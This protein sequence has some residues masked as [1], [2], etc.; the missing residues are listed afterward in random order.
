VF[1]WLQ[2]A[3]VPILAALI[4]CLRIVDVSLGTIRT[5]SVVEGRLRLSVLLGFFE[6]LIWITAVSQ[7]IQRIDES[8]LLLLAYAAGFAS[9]NAVGILIEQRI[10]MGTC[11]VRFISMER[12]PLLADALRENGRPVTTFVGQGRDGERQLV[13]VIVPRKQVGTLLDAAR[14]VDP[15]VFYVVERVTDLGHLHGARSSSL[16]AAQKRV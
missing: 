13:Y 7:V 1:H 5:I 4:F 14:A 2:T 11:V 8:P 16:A 15:G 12:G 6:V 10:A 3:P 9:G